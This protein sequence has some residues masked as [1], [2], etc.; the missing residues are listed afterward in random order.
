MAQTSINALIALKLR[1]IIPPKKQLLT[2][3]I[4]GMILPDL[5]FV[6]EYI[7]THFTFINYQLHNSVFHNIF[8]LPFLALLILITIFQIL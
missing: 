7:I 4:I 2:S 6:I 5:D 8:I 3:I 1:N